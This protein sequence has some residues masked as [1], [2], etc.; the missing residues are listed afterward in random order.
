[1]ATA[2]FVITIITGVLLMVY[3]KPSTDLAYQ[4]IKE[5]TSQ[6]PR[7]ASFAIS[8]AGPRS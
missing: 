6:S 2:S 1:M 8:T 4:S 5:F 7:D 3:Y